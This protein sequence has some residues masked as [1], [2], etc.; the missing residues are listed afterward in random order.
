MKWLLWILQTTQEHHQLLKQTGMFKHHIYVMYKR[1]DWE[2][3]NANII[4]NNSKTFIVT[5]PILAMS[6]IVE[7]YRYSFSFYMVY[8]YFFLKFQTNCC[9]TVCIHLLCVHMDLVFFFLIKIG[10]F[11]FSMTL[12]RECPLQP[13]QHWHQRH[14][15]LWSW[16]PFQCLARVKQ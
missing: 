3:R 4:N 16:C 8:W 9:T 12:H 15:V 13:H 11:A 7:G 2:T 1:L 5:Q 10:L 6:S 14:R